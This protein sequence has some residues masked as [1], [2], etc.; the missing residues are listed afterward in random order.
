MEKC[1]IRKDC[2]T[3]IELSNIMAAFTD[4]FDERLDNKVSWKH[5]TWIIST[6]L[7]LYILVSA[8]IWQQAKDNSEKIDN[9][10]QVNSEIRADVSYIKG[11]FDSLE[12]TKSE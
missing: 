4:K 6:I 7:G 5:F 8:V 2:V 11:G 1:P 9:N 12:I 10:A 3:R